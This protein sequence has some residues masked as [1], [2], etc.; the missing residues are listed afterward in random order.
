MHLGSEENVQKICNRLAKRKFFNE[1][2]QSSEWC[3]IDIIQGECSVR[4]TRFAIGTSYLA[5]FQKR[6]V[7][8]LKNYWT[9]NDENL[10]KP[11]TGQ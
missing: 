6:A 1:T 8:N 10:R 11:K 2:Y 3:P 5:Q 9:K 4:F 7:T